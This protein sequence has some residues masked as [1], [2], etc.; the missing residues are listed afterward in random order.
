MEG[1]KA[2]ASAASRMCY[3]LVLEFKIIF[4]PDAGYMFEGFNV[5]F[6]WF[7]AFQQADF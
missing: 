5:L 2:E 3:H 6:W 4:D 1:L 7:F